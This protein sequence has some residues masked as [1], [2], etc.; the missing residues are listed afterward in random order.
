M[1]TALLQR[2]P[3]WLHRQPPPFAQDPKSHGWI[4]G[5]LLVQLLFFLL[6]EETDVISQR[7]KGL[8]A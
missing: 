8:E 5:A 6:R 4:I 3:C 2:G 1:G 7:T